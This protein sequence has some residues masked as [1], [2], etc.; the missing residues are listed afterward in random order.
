MRNKLEKSVSANDIIRKQE[1]RSKVCELENVIKNLD[2]ALVGEERDKYNPLTHSFANGCYIR[3]INTPADQFIITKIHK[4]EHPFFLM[5]GECSVL[6][7][8]GVVRLEAPYYSITKPGTKRV[9]YTHSD[10]QW[11]TVHVTEHTD[12]EKIEKDIIAEDFSDP[13][14]LLEDVNRFKDL[15][16]F[17]NKNK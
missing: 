11:I 1:Y 10:V 15:L 12:L 6:T 5:K 9:I 17:N 16:D 13:E 4:I 8:D 14:I 3:E 2:G 7:E